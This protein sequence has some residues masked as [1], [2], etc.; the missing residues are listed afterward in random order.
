[1]SEVVFHCTNCGAKLSAGEEERGD[2][3]ECPVCDSVQIVP[4]GSSEKS[5][6]SV[7]STTPTSATVPRPS[8]R[9]VRV[10]KRKI[11]LSSSSVEEDEED[12]EEYLEDEIEEEVA[13]SFLR[14]V[15]MAVGTGGVVLCI[16]SLVW[17]LAAQHGGEYDIENWWLLFLGFVSVFLLSLM[18]FVLANIAFRVE[19]MA[20]RLELLERGE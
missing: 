9:V 3:F 1:M 16:L 18:G 8:T 6:E 12:E 15:G 7:V 19:R 14:V 13:G 10:P 2:E 5:A 11:V 20:A 4:G 17:M